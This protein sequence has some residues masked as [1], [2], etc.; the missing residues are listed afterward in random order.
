VKPRYIPIRLVKPTTF[1][2]SWSGGA[3]I[4]HQ[5]GRRMDHQVPVRYAR[6]FW[7]AKPG[8]RIRARIF[9]VGGPKVLKHH[10]RMELK[11][12][13][14]LFRVVSVEAAA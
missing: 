2:P 14:V 3:V 9:P 1:H 10:R 7:H 4:E 12:D 5:S 13:P 6:A 11:L 8:T